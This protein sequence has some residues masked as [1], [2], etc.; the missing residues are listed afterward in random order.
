MTGAVWTEHR[1]LG[2]TDLSVSSLAMGCAKLGAFWQ[3]RSPAAGRRA[4]E[5]ARSSGIT[6]F[7]TADCYARGIS[8]RLVGQALGPHRDEVVIATKVGLLKTPLAIASARRSSPERR[9]MGRAELRGLVPQGQ[10]ARCFAP[11]YVE[12]AVERSL[13]RLRTDRVDLLLLHDPPAEELRAQRFLPALERLREAGKIRHYGVA[14]SGA[15]QS[16]AALDLPDV[17]CL[18]IPHNLQTGATAAAVL[19]E[20]E[21]RGVAVVATAPLGDGTLL[22]AAAGEHP[23]ET[24]ATACIQFALASRGI[25]AVIVGMST[26]D[27]VAADVRAATGPPLPEPVVESIRR[28]VSEA[29]GPRC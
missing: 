21:R 10:A 18:A 24:V 17:S 29:A 15:E 11:V 13:R 12:K 16:R 8:E 1:P 27:H 14:C 22:R 23:P 26:P 19:P 7:D 4:L 5:A 28:C 20:A 25:S 6:F 3:G 2:D 9:P